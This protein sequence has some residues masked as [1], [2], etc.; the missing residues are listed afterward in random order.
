MRRNIRQSDVMILSFTHTPNTIW[1][2]THVFE[3]IIMMCK[4]ATPL[5]KYFWENAPILY[6]LWISIQRF[7]VNWN[8]IPKYKQWYFHTFY[9]SCRIEMTSCMSKIVDFIN[10]CLFF[11]ATPSLSHKSTRQGLQLT[12]VDRIDLVT[13]KKF[14]TTSFCFCLLLLSL[15]PVFQALLAAFLVKVYSIYFAPKGFMWKATHLQRNWLGHNSTI[16]WT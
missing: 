8:W 13:H 3:H 4:H 6:Q 7:Q 12:K 10:K 2:S 16:C 11:Y 9:I 1:F 15:S 14:P 5:E